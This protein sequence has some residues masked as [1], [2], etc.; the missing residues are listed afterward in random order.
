MSYTDAVCGDIL[1][2]VDIASI[3][4]LSM[5]KLEAQVAEAGIETGIIEGTEQRPLIFN[6]DPEFRSWSIE[7]AAK[8]GTTIIE[9]VAV[10]GNSLQ[11]LK[12]TWGYKLFSQDG[13]FLKNGITS[14][15][16]PEARYSKHLCLISTWKQY[17]SLIDKQHMIGSIYKI[18][19]LE[20][21]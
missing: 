13:T 11:S 9:D 18:K 15:L 3:G 1:A 21:R 4:S 8:T 5:I 7:S 12:P 6:G 16:I 10:H 19:S 2:A 14:K 20:V 17:R